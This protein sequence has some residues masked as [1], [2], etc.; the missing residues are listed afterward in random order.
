[1]PPTLLLND[2]GR[3]RDATTAA[4][5][6][7]LT[8]WWQA[9]GVADF[10]G[11]GDPD[12]VAGNLGL[13]YPYHPSANEPFE[14]YVGDFDRDGQD[15]GVPAYHEE[16]NLYPWFGRARIASMLPWVPELYPTLDT[17]A[18]AT[19]PE[20]L[21]PEG[22]RAAQRLDI[23]TLATMYLENTGGGRLLPRA[24]PRAAQI[25]TVAGIV[26]ADFDGD[27]AIDLVLAGN[28][29]AFDHSVPRLDGGV[30][31]FLRGDGAGGFVPVQP[32]MS[33]LWLEGVVRE[34]ALL[35][36]GRDREPALLAGVAGG[37]ALHVRAVRLPPS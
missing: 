26:P 16:G 1:M 13:N 5:L 23:R 35:R 33:G 29:H 21:R 34:L 37:E 4:G 9:L 31:L 25:S 19:L 14:L 24:L 10:D 3:L 22:M 28:L 32:S 12:V 30:G 6:D 7:G 18:R 2:G 36:V 20:I 8:G 17:F 15:E 11:D 27:G